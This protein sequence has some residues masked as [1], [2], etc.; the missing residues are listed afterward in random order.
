MGSGAYVLVSQN[1]AL[2]NQTNLGDL[3][4]G[5]LMSTVS[6]GVA[7]ITIITNNSTNWNTAYSHSQSTGNPH[8][9]TKGDVGLG[10]VDNTSDINKPVSTAQAAADTAALNAAKAYADGLVV[11]L[12]DDRGNYNASVN[13]FPASGGSGTAGAILKG[14]IWTVSVAGTLGGV[15]VTQGD[16]VRAL[17]DTPGQTS[18][19]WSISETNIGYTPENSTNKA[20]TMTGNEASNILYLTAKAIYDWATGLFVQKNG[21]IVGATKTKITYDAKGLVTGGA[22]ATTADI[23][24]STDKRYLT[25]AERTKLTNTTGTNSGNETTATVG[26]LISG[27]TDQPTPGDTDVFALSITST[28]RKLTFANLKA[29]IKSYYD[30]VTSTLTNKDISSATNTYRAASLTATGAVELATTAEIDAGTDTTRAMPI[31][32]FVASKRNVRYI[33]IY[34]VDKA[35]DNAV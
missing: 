16:L 5:L 23:A 33:D 1:S 18:T 34:A 32:Q 29:A 2:A 11:G 3:T 20:T 27:S 12:L 19:N 21:A 30:A 8:G 9:T 10:N 15:A 4:S 13:T 6:G 25:D 26:A 17:V 24:D 35:T 14:D 28:L 22:D 31:D 7:T